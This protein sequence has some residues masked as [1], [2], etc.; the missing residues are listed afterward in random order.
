[1]KEK[2]PEKEPIDMT[3][4][5]AIDHIFGEETAEE[6]RRIARQTDEPKQCEPEQN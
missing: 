5:E 3:T 2:E 6:L 4:E 1:M